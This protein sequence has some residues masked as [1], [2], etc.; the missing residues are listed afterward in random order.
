MARRGITRLEEPAVLFFALCDSCMNGLSP[1]AWKVVS[2]VAA[3]CLRLYPER[4]FARREPAVAALRNDFSKMGLELPVPPADERSYRNVTGVCQSEEAQ[5]HAVLSLERICHGVR[6]S[7]RFYSDYGTGLS[8]SSVAA[9]IREAI[10]VDILIRHRRQSS[11]GKDL[12]SVYGINW[13]RV[14]E[15]DHRRKKGK[16][17]KDPTL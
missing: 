1:N 6:T 13:K 17:A 4:D 14:R 3:Q 12:P 15:L 2:Y 11:A 10:S 5:R 7:K 16:K 8:K 9:A